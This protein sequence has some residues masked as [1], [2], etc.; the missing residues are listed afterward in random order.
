[1]SQVLIEFLNDV[2]EETSEEYELMIN[3]TKEEVDM[4]K[5]SYQYVFAGISVFTALIIA[6]IGGSKIDPVDGIVILFI[7]LVFVLL[8]L[9]KRQRNLRKLNAAYGEHIAILGHK[10][11][12]FLKIRKDIHYWEYVTTSFP[13]NV[14]RNTL[15]ALEIM[16]D[17]YTLYRIGIYEKLLPLLT[18]DTKKVVFLGLLVNIKNS[19]SIVRDLHHINS[20]LLPFFIHSEMNNIFEENKK[21]IPNDFMLPI[22]KPTYEVYVNHK[23]YI[24]FKYG[25]F[26]KFIKKYG[27]KESSRYIQKLRQYEFLLDENFDVLKFRLKK[28]NIA[29]LN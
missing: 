19:I 18:S 5:E 23:D 21:Y 20:K 7:D 10:K 28:N 4:V 14:V 11:S 16:D 24:D 13:S 25:G 6:L 26:F 17:A 12:Q 1:M 3:K 22:V 8:I 15:M 29:E 2:I 27:F 9:L